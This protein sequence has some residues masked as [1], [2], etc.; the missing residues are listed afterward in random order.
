[1]FGVILL[2]EI[3]EGLKSFTF[4][5]ILI[6]LTVLVP[7]TA[8]GQAKY[9]GRITDNHA[10]R[11]SLYESESS[12]QSV[13]LT[14][15]IPPLLPFFNGVYNSLPDEITLGNDS[16]AGVPSSEDLKPLEWISPGTDLSFVIGIVLTLL[17]ILLSH[18]TVTG[19]KEQGTLRMVLA[20]PIQKRKVL[21]AKLIGPALLIMAALF[22]SVL[23]YAA[24]VSADWRYEMSAFKLGELAIFTL[25]GLLTLVVFSLLGIAASTATK[26][27]SAALTAAMS[28]WIL[29][30]VVWPSFGSYIV[31]TT[32][33]V[34]P[35]QEAKRI[36]LAKEAELNQAE[37]AEHKRVAAELALQKASV[38]TAWLR[39]L[40]V[41][42]SWLERKSEELG[43]LVEERNRQIR[44]QQKIAKYV[45]RVSPYGAFKEI[46]EELCETGREDHDAFIA[47]ARRY[48]REEFIKASFQS[49]LKE[50]PWIA[51]PTH[52]EQFQLPPFQLPERPLTERL[53]DMTQPAL[54]LI[55]QI[56]VLMSLTSWKFKNYDVR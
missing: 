47:E 32:L 28:I 44:R 43:S 40:E 3:Q 46:L 17:A 5:S 13:V 27:S 10:I 37:L 15:S 18:D 35:K 22:Y 25:V 21:M 2:R 36:M 1:M 8:Y 16:F 55:I 14:R 48:Y 23:L 54:I 49:M 52:K 56:I 51:A 39:Y 4:V 29:A 7:L 6:V 45:L 24:L 9:F 30:V 33:P 34:P 31:S 12:N 19:E 53:K 41:R 20:S 38:E 50:T 11:Q 42:L 26:S